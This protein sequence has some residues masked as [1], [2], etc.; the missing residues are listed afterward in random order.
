MLGTGADGKIYDNSSFY[1]KKLDGIVLNDMTKADTDGYYCF[2]KDYHSNLTQHKTLT[3]FFGHAKALHKGGMVEYNNTTFVGFG[4]ASGYPWFG[5]T[6]Y[7]RVYNDGQL[8]ESYGI[9]VRKGDVAGHSS[10][11]II[12]G[13]ASTDKETR[14]VTEDEMAGKANV[15]HT[16]AI[17]EITNLQ[18]SLNGKLEFHNQFYGNIKKDGIKVYGKTNIN[19]QV[20]ND[21]N[22]NIIYSAFG[23]QKYNTP[24]Q[25][26]SGYDTTIEGVFNTGYGTIIGTGEFTPSGNANDTNTADYIKGILITP[27]SEAFIYNSAK[28]DAYSF[29]TRLATQRDIS[30]LQSSINGKQATLVSGTNIKT[31]NGN[32]ILGSG[33][34]SLAMSIAQKSINNDIINATST[35]SCYVVIDNWL[36]QWGVFIGAYGDTTNWEVTFPKAYYWYPAVILQTKDTNTGNQGIPYSN[37]AVVTSNDGGASFTFQLRRSETCPVYWIAIGGLH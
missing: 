12:D 33:N 21:S 15:G 1:D 26:H 4:K 9:M 18:T 20:G 2:R 6:K 10:A 5:L 37:G 32:S 24:T 27:T 25:A 31:I 22:G 30:S 13:G 36:V 28:D 29:D 35:K 16:H 17:S 8:V 7:E 19:D 23:H 34:L 11:Y 3:D 14:L